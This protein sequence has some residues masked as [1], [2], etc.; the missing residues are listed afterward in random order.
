MKQSSV[1]WRMRA[2][3]IK[4]VAVGVDEYYDKTIVTK[5]LL[6]Q[7]NNYPQEISGDLLEDT[8][9]FFE[10]MRKLSPRYWMPDKVYY[11][12]YLN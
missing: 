2:S 8:E 5:G 4:V 11:H 7:T 10:F 1:I 9:A 6:L 12:T 3:K